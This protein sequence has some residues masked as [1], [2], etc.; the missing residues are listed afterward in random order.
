MRVMR[1]RILLIKDT[2]ILAKEIVTM[3]KVEGMPA[4]RIWLRYHEVP[5]LFTF[6]N[7]E[8]AN[9]ALAAALADWR[10]A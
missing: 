3:G 7:D 6:D 2:A 5:L 9:R 8:D 10:G 1:G 4:F